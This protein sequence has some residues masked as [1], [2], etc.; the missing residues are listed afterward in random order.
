MKHPLL[1]RIFSQ[2]SVVLEVCIVMLIIAIFA[3]LYIHSNTQGTYQFKDYR[4]GVYYKE[5]ALQ[6]EKGSLGLPSFIG[7]DWSEYKETYYLYF[8]AL[9]PVLWLLLKNV[10][11]ITISFSAM[12]WAFSILNLSV[13][14]ILLLQLTKIL[15]WRFQSTHG[16]RILAL[17]VYGFGPLYFNARR[18]FIYE[19]AIII[20]STFA[21]IAAYFFLRYVF[22]RKEELV[23]KVILLFSSTLFLSLAFLSRFNLL[24]LIVPILGYVIFSEWKLSKKNVEQKLMYCYTLVSL[25][26]I[27]LVIAIGISSLYNTARF[28]NPFEFGINYSIAGNDRATERL[29]SGKTSSF[30]YLA[31]NTIQVI[32]FLPDPAKTPPYIWYTKPAWLVGDYPKLVDTEEM[33]SIFF[34][35]PLLLSIGYLIFTI[36]KQNRRLQLYTTVLACIFLSI[37]IYSAS[38][39]AYSRRYIQDYYAFVVLIAAIGWYTIWTQRIF[40]LKVLPVISTVVITMFLLTWT[41][42]LAV[43]LNCQYAFY[44]NFS[45]C[46]NLYNPPDTFEPLSKKELLFSS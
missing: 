10:F 22:F 38:F 19:T 6:F 43:N 7:G 35:S 14:Y 12:T 34:S 5:L 26:L 20:G 2:K 16:I 37:F 27:P 1:S 21:L 31:L 29:K 13:F 41:I 15:N 8:G 33:S 45:R 4:Q 11:H 39:T 32:A 28:D 9:P 30:S 40:S 3:F 25:A 44:S 46:L 17:I 42:A 24:F 18:Y 23:S 36:R